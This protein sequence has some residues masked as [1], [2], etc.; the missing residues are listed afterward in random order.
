MLEGAWC[1][2]Q[3]GVAG[4]GKIKAPV[5]HVGESCEHIPPELRQ[6][7]RSAQLPPQQRHQRQGQ[8]R[9]GEKASQTS[10]PET[11]EAYGAPIVPFANQQVG[12]KESRKDEECRYPEKS[13][14]GPG[15]AAVEEYR[16]DHRQAAQPVQRGKVWHGRHWCW[17]RH[18]RRSY[19]SSCGLDAGVQFHPLTLRLSYTAVR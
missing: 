4:A 13:T 1:R 10:D 11:A 16:A 5:G 14:P 17:I 3:L 18:G 7:L 8:E 2:E 12:D 6:L 19:S 15:E 9:G